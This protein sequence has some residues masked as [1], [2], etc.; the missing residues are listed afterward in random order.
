MFESQTLSG[1]TS[2]IFRTHRGC[3]LLRRPSACTSPSGGVPVQAS[4]K[5]R[6]AREHY[7]SAGGRC[8]KQL[9]HQRAQR[10][11]QASP[12]SVTDSLE[13]LDLTDSDMVHL[14]LSE[15]SS[16]SD[17]ML[18]NNLDEIEQLSA[19]LTLQLAKLTDYTV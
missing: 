2:R 10:R 6:F 5:S 17:A 13:T 1:L 4:S 9:G 18:R 8:L 19:N 15:D 12:S 3:S 11:C 14:S 7:R 16:G